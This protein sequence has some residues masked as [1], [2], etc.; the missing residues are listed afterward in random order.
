M[1]DKKGPSNVYKRF[2]IMFTPVT[3]SQ[4]APN[5]KSVAYNP[6]QVEFVDNETGHAHSP[7]KI[8]KGMGKKY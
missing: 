4:E 3:V 5:I 8:V 7:M 1:L 6:R 2:K